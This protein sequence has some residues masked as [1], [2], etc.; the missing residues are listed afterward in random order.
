MRSRFRSAAL[1]L[2]VSAVGVLWGDSPA[3]A[4]EMRSDVVCSDV[5]P[6]LP[7]VEQLGTPGVPGVPTSIP[8]IDPRFQGAAEGVRNLR[9]D[10]DVDAEGGATFTETIDYDFGGR[11]ERHGIYRHIWLTQPCNT[12]WD[13]VYPLSDLSVTSPTGAPADVVVEGGTAEGTRLRIGD[14]DTLVDGQHTYVVR[15]HLAG[16][17]SPF[18][19][20]DELYWNAVGV[21]WEVPVFNTVVSVRAPDPPLRA[22]CFAGPTGSNTSCDALVIEGAGSQFQQQVLGPG[23]GLTVAVAVPKGA[24][25]S[26]PNYFEQQ[27]SLARAFSRTPVTVGGAAVLTAGVLAGIGALAFS[28]GRDR[29][30]AGSPVDIAFAS[31]GAEGIPVPLF[32]R[33]DSPIEFAPPERLKPAQV[34]LLRNEEVRP[35]DVSATIVDLAVR[36]ALRIEEIGEGRDLDYRLVRLEPDGPDWADY[37]RTLVAALFSGQTDV[38]LSDLDQHFAGELDRVIGEVYDSGIAAGWFAARPDRV[39]LRWRALGV[40]VLVLGSAALAAAIAYTEHALLAVPLV[41]AGLALIVLAGRFPRRTPLGTGL[42]RRIGGFEHFMTDSE[43]PRAR[44][45]EQRS[46]FSDYLG[47]AVVLGITHRWART[48]EPLGNEAV[49]GAAGWYVGTQPFTVDHLTRATSSFTS[50]AGATLSSTP[51]SSS[52]SSGFSGGGSV[53]GG[54]GGG[55]GGSW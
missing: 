30:V 27:W 4:A 5:S 17:V 7:S 28:V 51:P 42:R 18:T 55:G 40:G 14:P 25:A 47:Y 12:D 2:F 21:G 34:A 54:G 8:P 29:R 26:T 50:S 38:L 3:S 49:A 1:A 41:V 20:R 37:E 39:R 32:E 53:G 46:I 16:V 23:Y 52:G 43:A 31:Q 48:F 15:Y 13:R 36:G 33:S 9:I 35:V 19:D 10:V 44:W 22:A 45:A 24:F 11:A 6:D